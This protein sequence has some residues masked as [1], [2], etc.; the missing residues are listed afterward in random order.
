MVTRNASQ[1][2]L[3]RV[4]LEHRTEPRVLLRMEGSVNP[5]LKPTLFLPSTLLRFPEPPKTR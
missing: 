3:R 4:P 2:V 5:K 1:T